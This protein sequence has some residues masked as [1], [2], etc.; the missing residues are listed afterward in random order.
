MTEAIRDVEAW[1]A[2]NAEVLEAYKEYR[3]SDEY[4]TS[5][6]GRLR[7]LILDF[8]LRSGYN[9]IFIENM[10]ALSPSYREYCEQLIRANEQFLKMN[11]SYRQFED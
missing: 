1:A 11:P 8:Q 9:E 10:K 2:N 6:A 5:P 7:A 4:K 3:L